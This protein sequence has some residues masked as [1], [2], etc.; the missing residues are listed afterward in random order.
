MDGD[1]GE[2][3][4]SDDAHSY[5]ASGTETW[6]TIVYR[7]Q[8]VKRKERYH[9][10]S[11]PIIDGWREP[12]EYSMWS[13]DFVRPGYDY[14]G[15]SQGFIPRLEDWRGTR[16]PLSGSLGPGTIHYWGSRQLGGIRFPDVQPSV[17]NQAETECLNKVS[18][19]KV[20]LALAVLESRQA[21]DMVAK[22]SVQLFN[23]L[24]LARQRKYRELWRQY[25]AKG[26]RNSAGELWL[27]YNYGWKPMMDDI[28]GA[29]QTATGA[30]QRPLHVHATRSVQR[31]F[32]PY[33]N[34]DLFVWKGSGSWE[35]GCKVRLDY[36]LRHSYVSTIQSLGIANPVETAWNVIPYS[37][38]IDWFLP[39]GNWL[40]GLTAEAGLV[41]KGGS[42]SMWTR[43]RA[44]YEYSHI[45]FTS[46][47]MPA[48]KMKTMCLHRKPYGESPIP[49]LYIKSPFST[50]HVAS[51]IALAAQAGKPRS[52]TN[53]Y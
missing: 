15:I 50:S 32:P 23:A 27:E 47:R 25:G 6:N 1:W 17:I 45:A 12:T 41:F 4:Y 43:G 13:C 46:G 40:N 49:G 19:S 8:D 53:R 20:D 18:A 48:L 34:P 21:V 10:G 3:V 14:Q 22:R 7:N 38:I 37:F 11:S 5:R 52:R 29:V 16:S 28:Y 44:N 36:T 24:R 26:K 42:K 35:Q 33:P 30:L 9:T 39:I 51:A 31:P 2:P